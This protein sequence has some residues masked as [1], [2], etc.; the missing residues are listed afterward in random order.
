MLRTLEGLAAGTLLP[1]P[2]DHAKATLA[3]I[4]TREDGRLDP[5]HRSA[6]QV[7]DRW[8]G[9]YPWPGAWGMFRGK[10]FL[11]HR[12]GLHRGLGDLQAG[13]LRLEAGKLLLGVAG[14][15]ILDLPEVQLEGKPRLPGASFAR[16]FQL[17]AG[18]RVE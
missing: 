13:E 17:Q 3:P 15:G 7:Y 9:F 1:T 2:Q 5:L 6:Q 11:I 10:R 4:L 12:M 16:D 14:G 18:E 8:R